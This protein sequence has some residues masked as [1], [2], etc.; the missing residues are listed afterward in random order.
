MSNQLTKSIRRFVS[1]DSG[2]MAMMCA[3]VV[4][5]LLAAAGAGLDYAHSLKV[6]AQLQESVDA[7]ALAG[8]G[9]MRNGG[10]SSAAQTAV[11][12]FLATFK[13][14]DGNA[15]VVTTVIDAAGTVKVTANVRASYV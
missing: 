4:V 8:A 5:P 6:Q 14:A 13:G 12:N 1:E 11:N 2:N 15:P 9:V 7:A 3:V 10:N